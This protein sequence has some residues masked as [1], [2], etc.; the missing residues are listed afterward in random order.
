MSENRH[1]Q[2]ADAYERLLKHYP[3]FE[4]RADIELMLGL[5]YGRYLRENDKAI[6]YLRRAID[7]LHD[8][9]KLAMA[10]T[11]LETLERP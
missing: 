3:T 7:G 11:E 8:D 10:R 4:H 5:I 9:R 6:G 2:A 1:S